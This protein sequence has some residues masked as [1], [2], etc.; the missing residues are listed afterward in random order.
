MIFSKNF[1]M[2]AYSDLDNPHFQ[3]YKHP[4]DELNSLA[5]KWQIEDI[6]SEEFARELDLRNVYPSNRNKFYYPKLK[7]LPTGNL[8]RFIGF[9]YFKFT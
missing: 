3:T 1:K 7:D 9:Y 4:L 6:Y 2:P 8:I 5:S